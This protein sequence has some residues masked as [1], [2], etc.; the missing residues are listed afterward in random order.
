MLRNILKMSDKEIADIMLYKR[1]ENQGK[2]QGEEGAAGPGLAQGLP[3]VPGMEETPGTAS[4][5]PGATEAPEMAPEAGAT[6]SPEAS[7]E[8]L[9]AGTIVN[10]LGKEFLFENK[11]DFFKILKTINEYEEGKNNSSKYRNIMEEVTEIFA[12]ETEKKLN[13]NNVRKQFLIN[14]FGGIDFG[15]NGNDSRSIY[16]FESYEKDNE[17]KYR[18]KRIKL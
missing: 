8:E 6:T 4:V 1:L 7:P 15:S 14:E 17:K 9:A 16:I 12:K 3:T 2:P 18:K 11:K 13:T 10:V 5:V